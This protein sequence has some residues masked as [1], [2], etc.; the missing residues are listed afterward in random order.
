MVRCAL[1]SCVALAA[2]LA[3]CGGKARPPTIPQV[4]IPGPT[5]WDGK[6][7]ADSSVLLVSSLPGDSSK[8]VAYEVNTGTCTV[9][10]TIV[11]ELDKL[12]K[13]ATVT[14]TDPREGAGTILVITNP[15]PPPPEGG[16]RLVARALGFAQPGN[17]TPS[18][19]APIVNM[20]ATH[21]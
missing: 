9:D 12:A 17:P 1:P 21:Q 10:R 3:S 2:V 20:T 14:L 16:D 18:C 13:L 19:G 15:P 11:D 8:F 6:G 5:A 4:S 7:S